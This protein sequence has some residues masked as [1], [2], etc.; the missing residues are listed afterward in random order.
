M[1]MHNTPQGTVRKYWSCS[2]LFHQS[3]YVNDY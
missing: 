2:D 3:S 1:S